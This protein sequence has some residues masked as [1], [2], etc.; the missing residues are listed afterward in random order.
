MTPK[1]Q[2]L[3]RTVKRLIRRNASQP[4]ANVIEKTHAADLAFVLSTLSGH[5]RITLLDACS[6]DEV[7]SEI[8]ESADADI[9]ASALASLP[10]E[11]ASEIPPTRQ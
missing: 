1:L 5:E 9:A 2:M 11:R 4:L 6:S 3:Q 8:L 7:R 10:A